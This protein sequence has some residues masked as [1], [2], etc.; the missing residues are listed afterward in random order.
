[1]AAC[2]ISLCQSIRASSTL[3]DAV[4]ARTCA[5]RMFRQSRMIR[6]LENDVSPQG[7]RKNRPAGMIQAKWPR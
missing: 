5:M 2:H 7:A 1:M 3:S 4:S 6:Y